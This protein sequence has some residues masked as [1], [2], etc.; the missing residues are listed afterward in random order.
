MQKI[1]S[2]KKTRFVDSYYQYC[3]YYFSVVRLF[4]FYKSSP[5]SPEYKF[6]E[7]VQVDLCSIPSSLA[8]S[9]TSILCGTNPIIEIDFLKGDQ[10]PYLAEA[11]IRKTHQ[12]RPIAMF[13]LYDHGKVR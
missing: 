1:P 2:P 13:S 10:E 11:E 12:E 8:F 9:T 6:E 5:L 3:K 7:I 4:T